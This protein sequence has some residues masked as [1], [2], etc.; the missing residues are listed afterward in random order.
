KPPRFDDKDV[1]HHDALWEHIHELSPELLAWL[2][3]FILIARIW[4]EQHV[5]WSYSKDCDKLT[6]A[7]TLG[8]MATV[9]L[10]PFGSSLVGQYPEAHS[11]VYIFS[12]IMV[13]NGIMS[14]A[15]SRQLALSHHLHG[16]K[17]KIPLI[18]RMSYHLTVFPATAIFAVVLTQ[19]HHPLLGM[20]G[21]F[22]EPV[23]AFAF[24]QFRGQK[25][26]I[27]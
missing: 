19:I 22:A 10:I 14:A 25:D 17:G 12:G 11:T 20:A 9:S 6:I 7:L 13:A 16:G 24:W 1:N 2:I 18:S 21:W 5:V 15:L 3:S 8:L 23:A 27:S 26:I 4:Q